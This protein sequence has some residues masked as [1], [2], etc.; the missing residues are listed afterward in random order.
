MHEAKVKS[1]KKLSLT[2]LFVKG[3]TKLQLC[4][5]ISCTSVI[6]NSGAALITS[7]ATPIIIESTRGVTVFVVAISKGGSGGIVDGET[8]PSK[9]SFTC[10][11]LDSLMI[12]D[13]ADVAPLEVVLLFV[14]RLLASLSSIEGDDDTTA[15]PCFF[16][17]S[18]L[19][20][21]IRLRLFTNQFVSC[22][23]SIPQ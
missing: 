14:F 18:N 3:S 23:I 2:I 6:G 15:E 21:Q 16:I 1:C 13:L 10:S 8:R 5:I 20:F 19:G 22:F 9:G 4:G 7:S 12:G 11:F 17:S